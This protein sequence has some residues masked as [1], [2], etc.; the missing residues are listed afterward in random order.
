MLRDKIFVAVDK[1][2]NQV[3][4]GTR[5]QGGFATKGGLKLSMNQKFKHSAGTPEAKYKIMEINVPELIAAQ[6]IKEVK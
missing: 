2:T 6:L 4:V 5:S 1:E 3:I